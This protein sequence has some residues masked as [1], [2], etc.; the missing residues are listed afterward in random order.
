MHESVTIKIFGQ[1]YKVRSGG[2]EDHVRELSKYIDSMVLDV[3]RRRNA[4]TTMELVAL[5]MLNMADDVARTKAELEK[6]QETLNNRIKQLIDKIE[7]G[8]P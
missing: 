2:S 8:I 7:T 4:A 3:Q 1:E 6:M 5:V